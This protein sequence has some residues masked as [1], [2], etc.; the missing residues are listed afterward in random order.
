MHINLVKTIL[1]LI[2]Y[3]KMI[4]HGSKKI[5]FMYRSTYRIVQY[6]I[7]RKS[8]FQNYSKT[9]FFL[10]IQLRLAFA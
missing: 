1:R 8:F 7:S 2:K 4:F 5:V 6:A 9:M 3:C 10:Q